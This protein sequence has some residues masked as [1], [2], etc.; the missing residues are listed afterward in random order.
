MKV[1]DAENAVLGR[2]STYVAKEVL[3]GEEI[4]IVNAEKAIVTGTDKK[5]IL[6]RYKHKMNLRNIANPRKSPKFSRRPDILVRKTVWGML[7]HNKRGREAYKR[8]KVYL[9]V[10]KELEKSE[11]KKIAQFKEKERKVRKMTVLEICKELGWRP[12]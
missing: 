6:E 3:K 2:L 1:I 4:R 11:K 8:V 10:P 7:P 5:S 9:K 12:A